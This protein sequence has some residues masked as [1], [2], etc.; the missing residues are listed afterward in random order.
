MEIVYWILAGLLAAV[1]LLTGLF[2]VTQTK[3][4]LR[5]KGMNWTDLY[6][7]RAVKGIGVAE[8]LGSIGLISPP[9]ADTAPWLAPVAAV[10][11]AII[12]AGAARAHSKLKEPIIPNVVLGV[13]AAATA[14]VGFFVWV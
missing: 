4:Q 3:E 13:L 7:E 12:M 2:K 8:V 11:L 5:A 9:I 1:F 6:S 10:G 14:V